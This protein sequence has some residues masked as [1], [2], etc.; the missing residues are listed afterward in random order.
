MRLQRIPSPNQTALRNFAA[1]ENNV[2]NNKAVSS[3]IALPHEDNIVRV[4]DLS[5]PKP[6]HTSGGSGRRGARRGGGARRG[7]P[8]QG[9][10]GSVGPEANGPSSPPWY[11]KQLF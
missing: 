5:N 9:A 8:E 6:E 3:V 7:R 11:R 1:P 2:R 10:D 4:L